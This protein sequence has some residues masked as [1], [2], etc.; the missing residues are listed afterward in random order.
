[1]IGA[2]AMS[3]SSFTVCMNALRLNRVKIHDGRKDRPIRRL[4]QKTV[5]KPTHEATIRV[6]GMMCTHCE[7]TIQKALE[8]LPFVT[9]A[10]ADWKTGEVKVTF[11]SQPD[12]NALKKAIEGEEYQYLGML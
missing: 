4:K 12:E 1:M 7:M 2:A 5:E 9:S 11:S 8:N 6:D 10:H 3:L